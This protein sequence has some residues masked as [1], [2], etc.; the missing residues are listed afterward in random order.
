MA[1]DWTKG[2]RIESD[3]TVEGTK[4]YDHTG[5][6]VAY[7]KYFELRL[8]VDKEQPFVEIQYTRK[9]FDEVDTEPD[10]DITS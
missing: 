9:L 6:Q 7:L 4:I 1:F 3:G 10:I 2:F 8:A 5:E